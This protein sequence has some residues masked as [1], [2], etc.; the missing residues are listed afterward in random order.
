MI[1]PPKSPLLF[2]MLFLGTLLFFAPAIMAFH[3]KGV[4]ACKACHFMHETRDGV[5]LEPA[6]PTQD[7]PMLVAETPSDLCLSCHGDVFGR[8]PLAPPPERGAGNFVFL[9]EDNLNDSADGL[10]DPIPG[11]AA[12]HNINAPSRGVSADGTYMVSPG[13][14]FPAARM[15]CTSCHDPHGNTNFR[16]LWGVGTDPS[17]PTVFTFPAPDADGLDISNEVESNSLHSAYRSGVSDWCGNCHGQ[18]H[19]GGQGSAF[20]HPANQNLETTIANY[21]NLYDGSSDPSGGDPATSYLAAVP[22]EDPGMTTTTTA[23]P[24]ASSKIMCLSCH[25]AH[26]SSAPHA[27]RWDFNIEYLDNDGAVSGSYPIP[28]PY[29]G[30][31]AQRQLCEKCHANGIQN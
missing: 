15:E 4:A 26:A 12:G 1:R 2:L 31:P 9:L 14:N 6:G 8:D 27:G 22:F 21:Y 17:R 20:V 24:T 11:D 18:Y 28:N 25:R 10:T 5:P 29:P 7:N 16:F 19:S 13:G 3:Q 30:D 23:G